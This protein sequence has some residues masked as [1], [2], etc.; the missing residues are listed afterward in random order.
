MD[1]RVCRQRLAFVVYWA[2][3]IDDANYHATLIDRHKC[4]AETPS[5][6]FHTAQIH[7]VEILELCNQRKIRLK[8]G[9]KPLIT[10]TFHIHFGLKLSE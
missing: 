8:N 10:Q 5:D 1:T 3:M 9:H 2:Q 4:T 7:F 6:R